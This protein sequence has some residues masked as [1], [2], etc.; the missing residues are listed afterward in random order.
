MTRP[1]DKLPTPILGPTPI[2]LVRSG[3]TVH[4]LI[5]SAAEAVPR[6]VYENDASF[7]DFVKASLYARLGDA[8]I[9]EH[10]PPI[11]VD[12]PPL[13]AA[14]RITAS[15]IKTATDH[16]AGQSATALVRTC[17]PYCMDDDPRGELAR[18]VLTALGTAL[19]GPKEQ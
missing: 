3:L 5:Y 15:S 16:R 19:D 4:G 13:T 10:R 17:I 18:Q 6:S 2:A 8:I 1:M 14:Q 7:R 9:A 11:T 12:E